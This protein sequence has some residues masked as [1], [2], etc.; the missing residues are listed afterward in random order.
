MA[1]ITL[2]DISNQQLQ[3]EKSYHLDNFDELA[4]A[5]QTVCN[6]KAKFR[7]GATTRSTQ[8]EDG[9]YIFYVTTYDKPG[10]ESR[11]S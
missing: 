5:R 4:T 6:W 2:T 11:N 10:T 8:Q 3:V 9:S 7:M 1:Q